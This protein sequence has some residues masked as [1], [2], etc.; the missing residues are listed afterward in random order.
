MSSRAFNAAPL[1][2][3]LRTDLTRRIARGE[4]KRGDSLPN[5]MEIAREY[6]LSPGTVR[7][8]LDWMEEAHLV[9]RQQG[10]GTFVSGVSAEDLDARFNKVRLASGGRLSFEARV[11]E[12]GLVSA[13]ASEAD[14]LGLTTGE[15]ILRLK[16]LVHVRGRP[17][18][19]EEIALSRRIFPSASD[20]LDDY[21][22]AELSHQ[23]GVLLGMGAEALTLTV[24]DAVTAE[25]LNVAVGAN[26]LMLDRTIQTIEGQPAEWRRCQCN[27]EGY[28]YQVELH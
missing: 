16:R 23:N 11:L 19:V 22:L 1:Y 20:K 5:E 17:L 15:Q 26:V 14:R 24:A 18:M 12:C 4:W 10:R 28:S 2:V 8:A 6:G 21:D 13:N 9:V 25:L 27:L 3:Q 7:K